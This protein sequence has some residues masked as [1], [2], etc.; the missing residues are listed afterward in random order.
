MGKINRMAE[1]L[2]A[3]RQSFNA[4]TVS[5]IRGMSRNRREDENFLG[6]F[7][8]YYPYNDAVIFGK[9]LIRTEK[10]T[11]LTQCFYYKKNNGPPFPVPI[12]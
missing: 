9:L 10:I 2:K 3:V 1:F 4:D 6:H 11:G 7:Q 5:R 12:L 8:Q